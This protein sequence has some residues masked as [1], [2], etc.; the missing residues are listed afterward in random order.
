MESYY[1]YYI[2]EFFLVE[3]VIRGS[4]LENIQCSRWAEYSIYSSVDRDSRDCDVEFT[5]FECAIPVTSLHIR[6]LSMGRYSNQ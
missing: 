3:F 1:S 5:Y 6:S 2:V 4:K